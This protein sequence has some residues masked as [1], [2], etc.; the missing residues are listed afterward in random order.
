MLQTPIKPVKK[1]RKTN[2]P[3]SILPPVDAKT[4][5]VLAANTLIVDGPDLQIWTNLLQSFWTRL[6]QEEE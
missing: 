5:Q 3:A 4:R 6:Q 1:Q 2:V